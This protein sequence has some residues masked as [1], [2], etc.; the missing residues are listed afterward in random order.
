MRVC[1]RASCLP[2][3]GLRLP[4]LGQRVARS[5][6]PFGS[7]DDRAAAVP[8]TKS[9]RPTLEPGNFQGLQALES[10]DGTGPPSRRR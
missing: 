10:M 4:F 6:A 2:A 7:A 5:L 1:V 9:S 3:L 8:S